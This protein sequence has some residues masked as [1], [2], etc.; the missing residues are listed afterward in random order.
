MQKSVMANDFYPNTI[1]ALSE[2]SQNYLSWIG[3]YKGYLHIYSYYTGA[4][5][6]HIDKEDTRK[7]FVSIDISKY[8]GK[9]INI[10][11]VATRGGN[12]DVYING[13][14]IRTFEAGNRK[15]DFKYTTLGDLRVGRNLKFVGKIY[16]FGIYGLAIS[17]NSVEENWQRAT[18]YVNK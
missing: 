8:Q 7:G 6:S 2:S 15:M 9:P 18:K 13:E 5:L 4:A 12:V 10:Q 3:V 17:E 16:E 11:V 14:K 1:V